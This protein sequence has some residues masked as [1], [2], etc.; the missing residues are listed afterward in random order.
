MNQWHRATFVVLA[1]V[2]LVT[3]FAV[4]RRPSAGEDRLPDVVPESRGDLSPE[5]PLLVDTENKTVWLLGKVQ[6]QA[7]NMSTRE[8]A[9]Y[10]AVVWQKGR[11]RRN[12]LFLSY[13]SDRQVYDA[14]L[15]L[16]GIPGNNMTLDSWNRRRDPDHPAPDSQ[17]VGSQIEV[18]IK[19]DGLS[20]AYSLS[21]IL[22]DSGGRGLAFR[23]A[24]NL[25]YINV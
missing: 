5:S 19:W 10:H 7:Y 22:S 6:A 20:R 24:G 16:G 9:Q 17:V 8:P 12:A 2:A 14:L 23:F 3:T 11:A 1:V 15:G 4:M 21:E 13:A 25:A 18:L